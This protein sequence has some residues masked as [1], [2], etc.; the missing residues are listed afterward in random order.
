[1]EAVNLSNIKVSIDGINILEEVNLSIPEK[2]FIGIIGPNGGGKTTLLKVLIGLIKPN[3]GTAKVFGKLPEESLGMI[4][5]VPQF[6]SFDAD[7][8]VSV[9]DVVMMGRLKH[10]KLFGGFSNEDRS[11]VDESLEL[12][13]LT[14]Y[15]KRQVG[16]LS[17]GEK[18]R[19]LIARALTTKPKLLLLDEPTASID[20]K[21]G[22]SFYDLLKK[23]NKDITVIL[24]SHDIGAISAYVNK[25][26]CLNKKLVYHNTKEISAEMLEH[27][28]HCPADLIAHGVPHRV[29]DEHNQRNE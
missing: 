20:S 9:L 14:G 5:Y 25:I 4:G 7:Y 19:V 27:V 8:P 2:E 15:R 11:I 10:K 18:Q 16:Y 29:L 23:L 22:K 28:Y 21:T 24:V 13:N 12:V 6:S 26:A 17:G 3:S 1:M